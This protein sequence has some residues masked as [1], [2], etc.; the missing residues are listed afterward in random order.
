MSVAPRLLDAKQAAAYVGV[1]PK[2]LTRLADEGQIDR[3]YIGNRPKYERESLDE[4]A[5]NLPDMPH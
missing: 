1:S 4:Y 2:T 5:D 3:K